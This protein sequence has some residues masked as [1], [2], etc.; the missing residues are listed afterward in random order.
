VGRGA[1]VEVAQVETIVNL[2]GDVFLREALEP[3]SAEPAGN[4]SE[5]GS[6][7]GV[8]P[9]EGL[10]R[11]CV[12]TVR[13]D[14]DWV[15]FRGA[16][17]DP[18]WARS[19]SLAGVEG[20]RAAADLLDERVGE[21]TESQTDRQVMATLQAAGVPAAFMAYPSDLAEDEHSVARRFPQPVTQPDLGRLLLEGPAFDA[22]GMPDPRVLPAP[23]LGE[24]TRAICR[25]ILGLSDP[26][27]EELLG[28]G[29]IEEARM[30]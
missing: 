27:I 6:P 18:S 25:E 17:G 28:E 19:S 2:L 23:R 10:E 21:W 15:R 24:H 8:Y 13:D 9:C 22:T 29:V 11:W 12:I 16:L 26:E 14:D 7:W 1:H 3:G 30:T 4:R 20:R 5:R